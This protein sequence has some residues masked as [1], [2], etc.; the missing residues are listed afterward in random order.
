MTY[1]QIN[2]AAARKLYAAHVPFIIVPCNM[3]PDSFYALH[4]KPGWMDRNFNNFYNEFCYYSC[5]NSEV[6]RYPRF[7]VE[8]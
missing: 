4:M 1:K 7:Y 3:R 8:E 6:G 2:K 5:G